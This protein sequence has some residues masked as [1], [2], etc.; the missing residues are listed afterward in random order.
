MAKSDALYLKLQFIQA[1]WAY[2]I[3]RIKKL[4]ILGV[5]KLILN[6]TAIISLAILSLPVSIIVYALGIRR[7]MF[8]TDRIGHLAIE[9]DTLL[10]AERLGL[11]KSKRWLVLAPKGRVANE[12]LLGYW[13]P[14][15]K[16]Y[17]SKVICFF[18]QAITFWPFVRFNPYYFINNI[19]GP[20]LAY[21]VNVRWAD[22]S[23][24][25]KL[26]EEDE[27]FASEQLEKM[28]VPKGAW[29]VCIHARERGFSPKDE[30][31]HFHRNSRIEYLNDAI[32]EITKRGGYVVRLGDPTMTPMENRPNVIDYA[33]HALK[34]QRLDVLLCAK[35]KFILG[36]TSGM[37]IVGSIFGVP[38]GLVNMIP[39]PTLGFLPKDISIPKLY[40]DKDSQR[41]LTFKEIMR[42]DLAAYRYGA[43]Y[44]KANVII[45][46]NS[47]EDICAVT[48]EMFN[49]LD[50]LDDL[51]EDDLDR[52][53]R[54]MELF[55]KDHYSYG[56]A[57]KV[58]A[59]FLKKYDYLLT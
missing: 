39:M 24:I 40:R 34:S 16:V 15:F 56:A 50:G 25:L 44:D 26:T 27:I 54:Y 30:G 43:L 51:Q 45:E 42:S 59:C 4:G 5:G 29:F 20:Q 19:I 8:F 48:I 38:S 36:N 41:Y 28:G 53:E 2:R 3:S 47:P 6:R 1:K 57:S 22:R 33:H 9:P 23:S 10:K 11:I 13:K 55:N 21:E 17:Q 14:H 46:E 37:F 52:H 58:A 12:H 18:L 35:A 32:K 31:V 7:V 49:R